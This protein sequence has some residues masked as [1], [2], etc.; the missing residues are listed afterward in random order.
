MLGKIKGKRRRGV[1][2]DKMVGWY[3]LHNEREILE[4]PGDSDS[5]GSLMCCSPWSRKW[6]DMTWRLNN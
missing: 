2:E 3:H 1:T 4:T 6:L 5:P